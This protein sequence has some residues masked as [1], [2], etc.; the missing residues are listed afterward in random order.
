MVINKT[1]YIGAGTGILTLISLIAWFSLNGFNVEME[2]DKYCSGNY[3]NPCEWGYNV[4]L[5]N[6]PVYY[7][8]NKNKTNII[9]IPEVKKAINCKKDGR[10]KGTYRQDREKYPCGIGYREFNWNTALT[11]KYSY[12]NKFMLNEK[13]EFK[14]VVFKNNP[15]DVIKFGGD[16]LDNEFDPYLLPTITDIEDCY[17][18]TDIQINDINGK[19]NMEYLN[20]DNKTSPQTI[21][22]EYEEYVCKKGEEIEY[23]NTT[24]CN[25]IGMDIGSKRILYGG[26]YGYQCNVK[27][28]IVICDSMYDGNGDG[29]CNSG[30]SCVTIDLTDFKVTKDIDVGKLDTLKIE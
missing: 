28:N 25:K 19:C 23:I 16:I 7:L 3:S 29:V 17:I 30:E 22:I 21:T 24:I 26:I 18:K 14:I 2:G 9:F 27:S 6:I 4:T 20:Y 10:Y 1:K 15:D 11:Y 5:K 8:Y 13:Q 12:I